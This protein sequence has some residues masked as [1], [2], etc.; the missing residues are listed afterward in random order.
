[1]TKRALVLIDF[2]NDFFSPKGVLYVG[3]QAR[4]II[5]FTV[6]ILDEFR[7][8]RETVI[9]ISDAHQSDDRELKVYPK[10]SLRDSQGAEIIG[11]LSPL[12]G[13]YKIT[14]RCYSGTFS[15][16]MADVLK[17]NY[18]TEVHLLGVCTSVCIMETAAGLF[19]H[20]F[21]LVTYKRGVA[22]VS[23]ADHT[24]AL[25]RMKKLFNLKI[26]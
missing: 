4:K 17:R 6:S 13:E 25:K 24:A 7:K 19:Y 14:K 9:F 3:P 2:V 20:G 26:I 22:D 10:H 21:N 1:M 23:T 12:P 5:P 16:P 11:E 8:N 15:T 18:V